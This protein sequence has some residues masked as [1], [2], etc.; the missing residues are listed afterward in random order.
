M[1]SG[2][3]DLPKAVLEALSAEVV[4]DAFITKVVYRPDRQ[5]K[6]VNS[7]TSLMK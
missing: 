2:G 5:G 4:T 1:G 7:S 3:I 6:A